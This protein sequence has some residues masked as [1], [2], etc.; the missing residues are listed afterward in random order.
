M[1]KITAQQLLHVV[2]RK[3]DRESTLNL[4]KQ[5]GVDVNCKDQFG[6]TPLMWAVYYNNVEES[7]VLL[8]HAANINSKTFGGYTALHIAV[9]RGSV[10]CV[11]L[12]CRS[13]ANVNARANN[14]YAPLHDAISYG[15]LG[16]IS[17]LLQYNAS[18]NVPSNE[19]FMPL[20]LA[21]LKG[22][23]DVCGI[24]LDS[25]A[26]IDAIDLQAEG[27]SVIELLVSRG[28]SLRKKCGRNR[29][30]LQ[31]AVDHGCYVNVSFLE[32]AES[33]IK[34]TENLLAENLSYQEVDNDTTNHN[35]AL[36]EKSDGF[37]SN[38]LPSDSIFGADMKS[39]NSNSTNSNISNNR[40]N[41]TSATI[42]NNLLS[43]Y[44]VFDIQAELEHKT[45]LIE[46]LLSEQEN[47]ESNKKHQQQKHSREIMNLQDQLHFVQKQLEIVKTEKASLQLDLQLTEKKAHKISSDLQQHVSK[48]KMLHE[49]ITQLEEAKVCKVCY[50]KPADT[51]LFPCSHF[52]LCYGC[53]SVVLRRNNQCPICRTSIERTM[54]CYFT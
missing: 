53:A 42:S 20:H 39:D 23:A 2:A 26:T 47:T 7:G 49:K 27:K 12:L 50:E 24:L 22:H 45:R 41:T 13:G 11:S 51:I 16:C 34:F 37:L 15:K 31:Y 28:A 18:V 10:S 1:F 19:G 9:A 33:R 40:S 5:N 54:L 8:S 32:L 6:F 46:Q 52:C 38:T 4:L 44:D 21:S 29:T 36:Y 25:G 35:I 30:P 14:G 43:G 3:G 48:Q 17:I